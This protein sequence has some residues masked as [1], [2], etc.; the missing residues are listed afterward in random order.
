MQRL[1]SHWKLILVVGAV[2]G[3]GIFVSEPDYNT[4]QMSKDADDFRS[5]LGDQ[6]T[7]ALV[8]NVFDMVFAACYGVLGVIAF[9][10]LAIGRTA[11]IGS[12]F[13]AGA[14][15]ADEIENVM[16][17][18]NITGSD[19]LSDGAVDAMT[20]VGLVK[21]VLVIVAI[22]L[23]LVVTLRARRGSAPPK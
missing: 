6:D 14:A 11:L 17:M 8:A 16:V 21:W 10:R 13:A 19:S 23:L 3:L 22:V 18:L 15:L 5:V 12:L 2:A 20:T 7:R 9:H 4:L 1:S